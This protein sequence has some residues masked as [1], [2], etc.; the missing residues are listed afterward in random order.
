MS[1]EEWHPILGFENEYLISNIG[2]VWS[3]H[4]NKILKNKRAQGYHYVSLCSCGFRQERRI[5]RL[6]AEAFILNPD[7]KPTVNHIDE[8][9]SNNSVKNLEWAT[10]KEQNTHGTRIER[11]MASTDWVARTSKID[12]R[13]IAQKHNYFEINRKQMKPVLQYD[14]YGSFVAC[15]DG[16]A[17]AARAVGRKSSNICECAKG[18]RKTSAGFKWKYETADDVDVIV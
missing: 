7:Q 16:V 10:I 17:T 15:H 9:K 18:R 2:R 4:S 5:H 3:N 11:A 6:V 8:N 12:Y 14:K 1:K 13:S